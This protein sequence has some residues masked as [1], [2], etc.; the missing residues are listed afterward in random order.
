MVLYAITERV[1]GSPGVASL[2]LN[3]VRVQLDGNYVAPMGLAITVGGVT[4]ASWPGCADAGPITWAA[5]DGNV[6]EALVQSE[7][8]VDVLEFLLLEPPIKSGAIAFD[9]ID[10]W[11]TTAATGMSCPVRLAEGYRGVLDPARCVI[12]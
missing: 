3:L 5:C 8:P 6:V 7:D 12:P 10:V 2:S 11:V 4:Y 1:D 9:D